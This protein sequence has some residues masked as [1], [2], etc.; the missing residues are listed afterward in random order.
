CPIV[1]KCKEPLAW[2]ISPSKVKDQ[3]RS[4]LY[5]LIPA[6]IRDLI[7]TFALQDTTS[8]PIDRE[9]ATPNDPGIRRDRYFHRGSW[10]KAFFYPSDIAFNLLLT[11][12]AVYLETYDKPL[13]VNPFIITELTDQVK[14]H[15][16][17][18]WQFAQITR[19]DIKLPQMSLE[20]GGLRNALKKW[21]AQAR[22]ENCYV[23][24]RQALILQ[25]FDDSKTGDYPISF[26][27]VLIPAITNTPKK[28][29]QPIN[30]VLSH[31]FVKEISA[32]PCSSSSRVCLAGKI[33]HLTLRLT[34]Q[35]WWTWT[36]DP[37]S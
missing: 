32:Q 37:A 6:E 1:T 21:E 20:N 2:S 27:N 8:C 16:L 3:S 10:R 28:R 5:S 36:D 18:P 11:C 29:P 33:T 24:P 4:S 13:R 14:R 17:L 35:D 31:A 26:D 23:V 19:L 25:D 22:H 12:K 15:L 34:A 7:F 30:D 9:P